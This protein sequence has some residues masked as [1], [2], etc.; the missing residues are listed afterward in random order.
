MRKT[1]TIEE[2]A[3]REMEAAPVCPCPWAEN[4][5][6]LVSLWKM[7][8]VHAR[9]FV[10]LLDDVGRLQLQC[11]NGT[12]LDN[13]EVI[14][15]V[16]SAVRQDCTLLGLVS[17]SKQIETIRDVMAAW[18]QG[19][20]P[21]SWAELANLVAE[22]R[23]RIEEDLEESVFFQVSPE[24]VRRCF[25][26]T[27]KDGMTE[28]ALKMPEEFFGAEVSQNFQSAAKAVEDAAKCFSRG[29]YTACVFHLL[30][31]LEIGVRALGKSLGNPSIDPKKN[32]TWESVLRKC[33][34]EL[35]KPHAQ[36]S[37]EWQSDPV[38]FSE[39][40]AN[41]RAVKDAWRN[42]TMHVERDYDEEE[43][44]QVLNALRAFMRR[45]ATR[46]HE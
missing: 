32:P 3:I 1:A 25:R 26:R 11:A 29:C 39:A 33:D 27:R 28:L 36:R 19:V 42:P 2:A 15:S 24:S 17:A 14:G 34:E 30:R 23:R 35:Q 8:Q 37:Q 43:A 7:L 46:L 41:L 20:A 31:V 16:L 10:T 6:R 12:A 38:F 21:R 4:P 22:L 45:L 5:Y 40:T 9:R 18:T 44:W 13:P